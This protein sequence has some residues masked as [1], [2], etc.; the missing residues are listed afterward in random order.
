M[1]KV[2][3]L[4]AVFVSIMLTVP[5]FAYSAP[6]VT[7]GLVGYWKFD[8]GSGASAYDSS[9]SGNNGV[10]INSPNWTTGRSGYALTFDGS[11]Y[12]DCGNAA[13]LHVQSYTLAAWIKPSAIGDSE[14]RIL[15]NGGYGNTNGA[16]DFV[17]ATNGKLVVLNQNGTGQDECWSQSGFLLPIDAWSFVTA[18]YNAATKDAKLYVNG[19]EVSTTLNTL[20]V[21]NPNPI[22]NM[23]IGAMGG[24]LTMYFKGSIDEVRVYNRTLTPA[25]ITVLAYYPKLYGVIGNHLV[26]VNQDTGNVA[27]VG[28]INATGLW[29][30][31]Y[32]P[33]RKALYCVANQTTDPELVVIDQTTAN[34]TVIGPIDLEG[35]S[36]T[37]LGFVEALAFNP[38]DGILYASA[39]TAAYLSP[40]LIRIDPGTGNATLVASIT[41]TTENDGDSLVFIN[42]TLYLVDTAPYSTLYTANLGTGVA[43]NLGDLNDFR[44]VILAYNPETQTLLGSARADRLLIEI[45]PSTGQC[46]DIGPTHT[47]DEFGGALLGS[48]AVVFDGRPPDIDIPTK[49][50]P[51]NNVQPYQNVTISV[52][53]T[54]NLSGV[55]NVT[56]V[57]SLD[58]G[59]TW[60]NPKSMNLNTTSSLYEGTIPGQ[61]MGTEVRFKIAAFDYAENNVTKDGTSLDYTYIVVPEFPTALALPIFMTATLLAIIFC[62]KK[63]II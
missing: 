3:V 56:L 41:G 12:V 60:E 59:T 13:S 4:F 32:D 1:R 63:R 29:G 26:T 14:H 47:T 57:Y 22:Y 28:V 9:V 58:N 15:S 10:L 8:E 7:D 27:E 34:A 20:R 38:A 50:P 46:T 44:D 40:M 39:G 51:A 31:T 35:Y 24:P 18:T 43:T 55:K 52:N 62:R 37:Y 36:P 17:I 45:S 33:Y 11:N 53:V 54:D 61:P 21:P 5:C 42:G 48:M 16:V 19:V 25:E 2:A 49:D 6:S 30:L 23:H